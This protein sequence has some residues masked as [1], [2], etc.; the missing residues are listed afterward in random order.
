MTMATR[1][2]QEKPA[3]SLE[4]LELTSLRDTIREKPPRSRQSLAIAAAAVVAT[5]LAVTGAANASHAVV[6]PGRVLACILVAAWSAAALFVAVHRPQEPLSRIIVAGALA[7]GAAV[8]ADSFVGDTTS[9]TST[10]DIASAVVSVAVTLLVAIGL[11]IVLGLPNG[12]LENRARRGF[13]IGGYVAALAFA[14]Y[15]YSR[16]PDVPLGALTIA[17]GLAVLVGLVGYVRRCRRAG[18]AQARARLQWV[19]WGVVVA[20]A[21]SIGTV[22][23]NALLSW[24]EPVAAIAV[25][26]TVLVPFALSMSAS[27][28]LAVRIDRLLVHSITLTGLV[29]LVGGSYLLIVLGLGRAPT[30]NENT[31]IGL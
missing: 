3:G 25:S 10:K 1:I 31:R 4:P 9:S 30:A 23:L 27:D 2:E 26:S 5:G 6:G 19:A 14:G 21:I 29:G 24:P 20:A 15:L 11:H 28:Q 16:R 8:L 13:A 7:G 18:T 12:A 17:A 22:V